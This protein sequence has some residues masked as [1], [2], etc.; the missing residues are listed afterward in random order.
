MTDFFC[1]VY[2]QGGKIYFTGVGSEVGETEEF[3]TGSM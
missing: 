1:G 3:I 2:T